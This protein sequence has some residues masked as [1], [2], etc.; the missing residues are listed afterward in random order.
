MVGLPSWPSLAIPGT[1]WGDT[2]RRG[3][4]KLGKDEDWEKKSK[5]ASWWEGNLCWETKIGRSRESCQS[6]YKMRQEEQGEGMMAIELCLKM[7]KVQM[8]WN[9]PM[10]KMIARSKTKSWWRVAASNERRAVIRIHSLTS[11]SA[12]QTSDPLKV[13]LCSP[14]LSKLEA[15]H[16]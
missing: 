6:L 1:A 8:C 4:D 13:V 12:I 7:I 15:L 14:L 9:I 16:W 2:H 10:P 5:K 3:P 11:S